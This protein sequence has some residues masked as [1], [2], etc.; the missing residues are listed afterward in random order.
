[1]MQWIL[2]FGFNVIMFFGFTMAISELLSR[3]D[4]ST[5]HSM[6]GQFMIIAPVT[7]MGPPVADC[8]FL[9]SAIL[10]L[11]YGRLGAGLFAVYYIAYIIGGLF[12]G[13]ILA[14]KKTETEKNFAN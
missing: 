14:A 12:L 7:L 9:D 6:N 4:M 2:F 8:I 5:L 10:E 1:M 11:R 3:S 13:G